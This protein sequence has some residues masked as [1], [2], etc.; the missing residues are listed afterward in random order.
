MD[1]RDRTYR[2]FREKVREAALNRL[3]DRIVRIM[4][5]CD[6]EDELRH[7]M[8]RMIANHAISFSDIYG[9]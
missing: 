7:E 1:Q 9:G 4:D 3:L 2:Q 5:Y 6:D 8:K